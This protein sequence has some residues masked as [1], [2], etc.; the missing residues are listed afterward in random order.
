MRM[1]RI[2]TVFV[3]VCLLVGV[4]ATAGAARGSDGVTGFE[5][6]VIV[7]PDTE[8]YYD[9]GFTLYEEL[10]TTDGE[11]LGWSAGPCFNTN[12]DLGAES[13][14]YVCDFG[15][16]FPD[17]K[18]TVN[19]AI[20]MTEFFAGDTVVAVTGGTG[21]FTHVS[22]EMAIIPAEDFSHSRLVFEVKH[23]KAGY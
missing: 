1:R 9:W 2:L 16:Q 20:N 8:V 5:V 12:P 22:G 17:G 10:R 15:M 4:M 11:H 21:K 3:A 19:G 23:A 18:I 14:E 7:N 6:N 13:A